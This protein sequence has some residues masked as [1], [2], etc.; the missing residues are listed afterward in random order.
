MTVLELKE[1][2][3][4]LPDDMEVVVNDDNYENM[5]IYNHN[6]LSDVTE[7]GDK[8]IEPDKLILKV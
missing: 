2:L 5:S 4:D 7:D 1:I 6:L 3:K 8:M